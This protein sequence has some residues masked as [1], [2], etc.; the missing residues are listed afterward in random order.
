MDSLTEV[1]IYYTRGAKAALPF[2]PPVDSGLRKYI[3]VRKGVI[4]SMKKII[5]VQ[6][7]LSLYCRSCDAADQA[8]T[9]PLPSRFLSVRAVLSESQLSF[10]IA[11]PAAHCLARGTLR[12]IAS[13]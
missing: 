3:Q 12:A 8:A 6:I 5:Q 1:F 7:G 4:F 10:G 11:D 9:M 13:R 2:P